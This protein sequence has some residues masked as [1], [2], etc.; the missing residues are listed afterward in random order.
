M[1]D[2]VATGERLEDDVRVRVAHLRMEE[3]VRAAVEIGSIPLRV[4]AGE[5]DPVLEPEL[6]DQL[7]AADDGARDE[8]ARLGQARER[9][10]PDRH[11]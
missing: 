6:A 3:H 2:G 10:E 8:Q 11:R 9:L 4:P 5:L 1:H 7:L